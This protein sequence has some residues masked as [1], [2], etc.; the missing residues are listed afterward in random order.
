MGLQDVAN[1]PRFLR[2][3][4]SIAVY[5]QRIGTYADDFAIPC[6]NLT[7]LRQAKGLAGRDTQFLVNG[8]RLLAWHQRSIRLDLRRGRIVRGVFQDRL[9]FLDELLGRR[10]LER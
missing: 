3:A 6:G 8:T 10:Q 1:R 7:V 2:G 5:A 9:R 4:R